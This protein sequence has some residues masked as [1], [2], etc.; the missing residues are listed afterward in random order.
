MTQLTGIVAIG[1]FM[2]VTTSI[3]WFILKVSIGL[4]PSEE[5]EMMGLDRAECG[6]E[7][8]PEFGKGSQTI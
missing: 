6:M 3:V 2:V 7:A 8:Y 5:D 1:A 4:R